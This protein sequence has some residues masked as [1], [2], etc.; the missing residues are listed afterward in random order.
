MSTIGRPRQEKVSDAAAGRITA[1]HTA[2]EK[3]GNGGRTLES[4]R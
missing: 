1:K 2:P 4:S 3:K